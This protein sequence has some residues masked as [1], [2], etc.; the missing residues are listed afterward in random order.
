MRFMMFI[1]IG[2]QDYEREPSADDAAAMMK[3]NEELQK[4][5]ALLALDGLQAPSEGATITFGGDGRASVVDGPFAEAKEVVGGYWI[6]QAKTKEEAVEWAKRVPAD[7]GQ[8]IE[9]RRIFDMEDYSA[10][11]QEVA[12]RSELAGSP[13]PEQTESTL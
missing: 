5:G 6:I 12:Q 7:P 3:Y 8:T 9:L 13:P 2:P 11:V 10:E 4:A 1:K